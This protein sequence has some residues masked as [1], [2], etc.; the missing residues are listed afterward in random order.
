MARRS[1][2]DLL[3]GTFLPAATVILIFVTVKPPRGDEVPVALLPVALLFYWAFFFAVSWVI[4]R[5]LRRLTRN[6][7]PSTGQLRD[8]LGER[9]PAVNAPG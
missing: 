6:T 7:C 3:L 5:L 2:K 9:L 4:V 8:L 1:N